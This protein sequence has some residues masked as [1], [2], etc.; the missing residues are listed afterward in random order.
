MHLVQLEHTSGMKLVLFCCY[1]LLHGNKLRRF[2]DTRTLMARS[3][4]LPSSPLQGRTFFKDNNIKSQSGMNSQ[5]AISPFLFTNYPHLGCH[6]LSGT[7]HS[8][9]FVISATVSF[10]PLIIFKITNARKSRS[11]L[12]L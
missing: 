10:V 9:Y 4:H 11:D 5:P 1:C 12:C 6:G 2:Y 8:K 7:H 3:H